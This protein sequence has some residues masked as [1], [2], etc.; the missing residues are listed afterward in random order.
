VADEADE[1]DAGNFR[2]CAAMNGT[3]IIRPVDE[4]HIHPV[5]RQMNG[6]FIR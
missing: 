5:G 2:F 4:W 6:T 1:A 3:F